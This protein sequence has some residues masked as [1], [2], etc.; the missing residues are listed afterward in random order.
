M[1]KLALSFR[2]GLILNLNNLGKISSV[3]TQFVSGQK[4]GSPV[5][6]LVTFYVSIFY[7]CAHC[8]SFTDALQFK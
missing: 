2:F 7:S 1:L 5:A 6:G 4:V 3:P 8:D